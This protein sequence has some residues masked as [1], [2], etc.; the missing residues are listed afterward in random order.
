MSA[1]EAEDGGDGVFLGAAYDEAGDDV[2]DTHRG[3]GGRV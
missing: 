1:M 2:G 3:G